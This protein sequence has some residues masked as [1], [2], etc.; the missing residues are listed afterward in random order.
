VIREQVREAGVVG[1]FASPGD[2]PHPGVLAL[3]GSDGGVPLYYIDFLVEAGFAVFCLG[4]FAHEDLQPALVEVPLERVERALEWMCAR[5]DVETPDGRVAVIGGSKGGELALLV[6]ATLP[7]LIGPVV[8]YTP[9]SVVWMGM[10]FSGGGQQGSSWTFRGRPFPFVPYPDGVLPS[11]SDKGMAL[12]PL[13]DKGLDQVDAVREAAIPIEKATGPILL[14]SGGDDHM[15][16]ATRMCRMLVDRMRE[17][18]RSDDIEHLDFPS[19]G[20]G[21]LQVLALPEGS[22]PPPYDLGGS[23]E[24]NRAATEA[25]K[26]LVFAYLR[27]EA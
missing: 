24:T 25:A 26:E 14:L 7:D 3:G 1:A 12:L 4:Y 17:H 20:H 18:G 6:A 15:W 8:A 23:H 21:V 13:Y 16:N 2:G 10:D 27:G 11:F 5:P 22:A 9:S 19:A